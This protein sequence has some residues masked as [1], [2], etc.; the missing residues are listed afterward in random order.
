MSVGVDE[1]QALIQLLQS[2]QAISDMLTFIHNGDIHSA[3]CQYA[4]QHNVSLGAT[5]WLAYATCNFLDVRMVESEHG[6]INRLLDVRNNTVLDNVIPPLNLITPAYE[7]QSTEQDRSQRIEAEFRRLALLEHLCPSESGT[8]SSNQNVEF[9]S[10]DIHGPDQPQRLTANGRA[11]R[12]LRNLCSGRS[13]MV[14]MVFAL[15]IGVFIFV[16][17]EFSAENLEEGFKWLFHNIRR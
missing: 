5:V 2:D 12:E 17:S 15:G 4:A 7:I 3:I 13:S 14:W 6:A 8:N 16:H 1:R 10:L 9:H 11:L